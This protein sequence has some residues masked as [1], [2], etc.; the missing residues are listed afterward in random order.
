MKKSDINQSKEF[1][2]KKFPQDSKASLDDLDLMPYFPFEIKH[3]GKEG[4]DLNLGGTNIADCNLY[5]L[6]Y[7]FFHLSRSI[8]TNYINSWTCQEV[9]NW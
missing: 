3:L 9:S 2:K 7:N 5:S 1:T 8:F 6:I 4:C